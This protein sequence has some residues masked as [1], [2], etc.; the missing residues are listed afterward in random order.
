MRI[1]EILCNPQMRRARLLEAIED[2]I[3]RQMGRRLA[4]RLTSDRTAIDLGLV[5]PSILAWNDDKLAPTSEHADDAMRD[6]RALVSRVVDAMGERSR[7]VLERVIAWYLRDRNLTLDDLFSTVPQYVQRFRELAQRNAIRQRDLGAY[8]TFNELANAVDAAASTRSRN[9]ER[10]EERERAY[11]ESRIRYDDGRWLVVEPKTTRAS[12]FW[13]RGT[14]WCIAATRGRNPFRRYHKHVGPFWFVIDR[15]GRKWAVAT[16]TCYAWDDQDNQTSLHDLPSDVKRIFYRAVIRNA[17]TEKIEGG[18][19]RILNAPPKALN[20][21]R[22]MLGLPNLATSGTELL[23]SPE[24]R[25]HLVSPYIGVVDET[26]RALPA[27]ALPPALRA[28]VERKRRGGCEVVRKDEHVVV[29]RVPD[30]LGLYDPSCPIRPK[31]RNVVHSFGDSIGDV[32]VVQERGGGPIWVVRPDERLVYTET[33]EEADIIPEWL[34]G[35]VA[36]ILG[37]D[38]GCEELGRKGDWRLVRLRDPRWIGLCPA[39]ALSPNDRRVARMHGPIL[40]LYAERDPNRIF[41]ISRERNGFSLDEQLSAKRSRNRIDRNALDL[42]RLAGIEDALRDVR[43]L[44]ADGR[45]FVIQTDNDRAVHFWMPAYA[46]RV[47]ERSVFFVHGPNRS[48]VVDPDKCRVDIVIG[49]DFLH[50]VSI[51]SLQ[52]WIDVAET[53]KETGIPLSDMIVDCVTQAIT[54]S[55]GKEIPTDL[56]TTLGRLV[57][58]VPADVAERVLRHLAAELSDEQ[59]HILLVYAANTTPGF[60][61]LVARTLPEYANF[62]LVA[63]YALESEREVS[64]QEA[65]SAVLRDPDLPTRV[66]RWL[67][68]PDSHPFLYWSAGRAAA[69]LLTLALERSVPISVAENLADAIG[70]PLAE[71]RYGMSVQWMI[72]N[73]LELVNG[74][75]DPRR[76]AALLDILAERIDFVRTLKPEVRT[77]RR[78]RVLARLLRRTAAFSHHPEVREALESAAA[79]LDKNSLP[80]IA[81]Y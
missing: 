13:G 58:K 12:C 3:V 81:E 20:C 18:W 38:V 14:R 62:A 40:F 51:M 33:G 10:R 22:R 42:L 78:R 44:R 30:M 35:I 52:D 67:T 43:V 77:R 46:H 11:R 55:I 64:Q 7:P 21:A 59:M 61:S 68:H 32:F 36:D 25:V 48:F 34:R 49:S 26:G 2:S 79:G 56:K 4:E 65:I 37:V 57:Q 29:V 23:V 15:K 6:L 74:R 53:E 70:K 47:N 5:A 66:F 39:I 8:R 73:I 31:E 63:A 1:Q 27:D 28:V 19:S 60:A 75:T 69:R 76:L 17:T 54:N 16:D 9:Q 80:A 45:W 41:V 24:G 72:E 50:P 71:K